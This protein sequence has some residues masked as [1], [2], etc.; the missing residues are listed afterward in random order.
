MTESRK[1]KSIIYQAENGAIEL[2]GDF[3]FETIWATQKQMAEVFG[4]TPQNVTIHLKNIFASGELDKTATCKE[5]LQVQKEG[6]R[7]V[8]RKVLEYNLDVLISV[9]YRIDSVV[10]TNF[11]KWA[12]GVIKQHITRGYTINK[13]LLQEKESQ[14]HRAIADI[15]KIASQGELI[16]T[17]EVLDII[18]TFSK[19]WFSLQSYDDAQVPEKGATKEKVSVDTGDLYDD[20]AQLKKDLIKKG[21][22]TELFAQ[23]K[24]AD[25]LAGIIGNVMQSMQGKD[26]YETV[27]EKAAHLLYFVVKNHVFN[28]GNK[29]TGA[30]CFVWFLRHAGIDFGHAITP[31]ALTALTLLVAQSDPQDKDRVVGLILL[32]FER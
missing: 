5:S 25:A 2:R 28:D 8:K 24:K 3:E 4:V 22:A 13:R 14:Y 11:R 18:Q 7:E 32:M 27:E 10:G 20:L 26:L 1:N 29:R 15:K 12:T 23:E 9:G 21:E 6:R 19:T 31:E 30:F 16:G 17:G